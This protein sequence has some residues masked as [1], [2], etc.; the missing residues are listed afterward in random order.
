MHRSS[1][2][3]FSITT[4]GNGSE[5]TRG[6]PAAVRT[7]FMLAYPSG[8]EQWAKTQ[9]NPSFRASPPLPSR[10]LANRGSSFYG[11]LMGLASTC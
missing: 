11:G 3:A 8:L 4:W 5:T 10:P 1:S 6:R 9:P 7:E 2:K